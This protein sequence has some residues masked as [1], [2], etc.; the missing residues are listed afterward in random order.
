MTTRAQ[1]VLEEARKLSVREKAEVVATLLAD[2]EGDA[3]ADA[4]TQWAREIERRARAVVGGEPSA[5]D[6]MTVID[7]VEAE[8]RRE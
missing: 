3:D 4:E 6:A 2:L 7:D 5:G 1:T 8:L